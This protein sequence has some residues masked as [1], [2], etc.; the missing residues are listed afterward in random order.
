MLTDLIKSAGVSWFPGSDGGNP[1]R[2]FSL[3]MRRNNPAKPC[4]SP[5]EAREVDCWPR[6][7]PP[8]LPRCWGTCC[9][10]P[11]C[12]RRT[13]RTAPATSQTGTA[14]GWPGPPGPGC[15]HSWSSSGGRGPCWG[16]R[17]TW[18]GR[19]PRP[20]RDCWGRHWRGGSGG[21][22]VLRDGGRGGGRGRDPGTDLLLLLQSGT[23][24]WPW[25]SPPWAAW[26]PRPGLPGVHWADWPGWRDCH[27]KDSA[28]G[29]TFTQ[30]SVGRRERR[31]SITMKLWH[32]PAWR[33]VY[34]DDRVDL[35]GFHA[36]FSSQIAVG[37]RRQLLIPREGG[38][39]E[40]NQLTGTEA[41]RGMKFS[42]RVDISNTDNQCY[43]AL[44]NLP[45]HDPAEMLRK[46]DRK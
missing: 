35:R 20:A 10:G 41:E 24:T 14:A 21:S 5:R 39:T 12:P 46:S 18:W 31:L 34:V 25:S 43:G 7:H 8:Q 22:V 27:G 6:P 19:C 16:P 1:W 4:T 30:S 32:S 13:P 36:L 9:W 11:V 3:K 26:W 45:R 42:A 33:I 17:R 2:G 15:R 28:P 40:L 44:N 37:T 38:N 23:L 29:C